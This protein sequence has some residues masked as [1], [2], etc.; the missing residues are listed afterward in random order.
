MHAKGL[1]A[2]TIAICRNLL[3]NVIYPNG[4]FTLSDTENNTCTNTDADNM[5]NISHCNDTESGND[6]NNMQNCL[7]TCPK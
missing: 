6:A 4:V 7:F 1:D 3:K 5:Q 2:T